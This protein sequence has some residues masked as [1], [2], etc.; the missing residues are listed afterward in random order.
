MIASAFSRAA[1]VPLAPAAPARVRQAAPV[2]HAEPRGRH[3][4][5]IGALVW[6]LTI[7]MIA[8]E[9]FDYSVVTTY[10]PTSGG[11]LSRLM[12]ISLLVG[13][14]GATIACAGDAVRLL[15]TLNPWLLVFAGLAFVSLAWS[16][17]VEVTARRL[18]RVATMLGVAFAFA[19]VG[20]HRCRF[21]NMVRPIITL[22]LA[23]SILFGIAAPTLAIHQDATGVLAGAWHGLSSHK[24][25]LGDLACI[26]LILWLHAYLTRERGLV[27]CVCGGLLAAA[28]LVLSKSSTSLVA[29]VFCLAFLALL[30]RLPVALQRHL[31]KFVVAFL[32]LLFAYSIAILQIIPGTEAAMKALHLVTGK[33]GTFTGR[34]LIWALIGEHVKQHPLLGT[35]YG[36]YW[37]FKAGAPS[38]D[39]IRYLR[40]YPGSAHNG[41]L[42]IVN[43]L[44]AIGGAVLLAYLVAFVRQAL[45]L[46]HIDRTTAA[47]L[48][49]LFLH[50]CVANLSESR[51]LSVFSVDF[52]IMTLAT[53]HLGRALL[54]QRRARAAHAAVPTEPRLAAAHP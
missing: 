53:A 5:F 28:C 37:T 29:S 52:V 42:E 12:W 25:G 20:W 47:L 36:A 31:A 23:G 43:D 13:G 41:Y 46:L 1:S 50:Q 30:L 26:G 22:V 3:A 33:D 4:L 18:L 8:P 21:Q 48:L 32:V 44:G 19:L 35:G 34:T 11:A 17:D 7:L 9:G 24:N 14:I 38:Y 39:F 10:A 2:A 54:E 6:A 16:I 51:W 45:A 40:F 27:A 15:R 49:A